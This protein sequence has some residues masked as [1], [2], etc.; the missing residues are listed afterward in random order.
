MEIRGT[1]VAIRVNKTQAGGVNPCLFWEDAQAFSM[2]QSETVLA[3][4]EK[5]MPIFTTGLPSAW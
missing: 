4:C 5:A 2:I 1:F 3:S